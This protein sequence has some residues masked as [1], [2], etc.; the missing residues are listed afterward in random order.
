MGSTDVTQVNFFEG[1]FEE[2]LKKAKKSKKPIFL[3]FYANW[4]QPCK[5]ME[6]YSFSDPEFAKLINENFI[7]FKVK[8]DYF[9]GMDIAEEYGI[10]K[11]PTVI[12]TDKKGSE[13]RRA[14]GF[15]SA[16]DLTKIAK[17]ILK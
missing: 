6:K 3:N 14:V 1:T 16:K 12:F 11:H 13:I 8:T 17:A 10:S 7:A 15:K 5:N 2:A 9:W 4:S